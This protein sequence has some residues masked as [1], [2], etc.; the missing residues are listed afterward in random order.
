MSDHQKLNLAPPPMNTCLKGATLASP[1][2]ST[3]LSCLH[4]HLDQ[5]LGTSG[6][7]SSHLF[8]IALFTKLFLH[9]RWWDLDRAGRDRLRECP[10]VH[11]LAT[12]Q[13]QWTLMEMR[14]GELR[15]ARQK[16]MLHCAVVGN[17]TPVWL[18]LGCLVLFQDMAQAFKQTER[19][20]RL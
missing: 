15:Q 6:T 1:Q 17:M 16:Q 11:V 12:E 14:R 7:P 2:L 3:H 18:N 10:C 19:G 8:C 4:H 5:C 9:I 13:G 20:D